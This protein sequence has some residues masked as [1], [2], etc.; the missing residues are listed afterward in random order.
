[1]PDMIHLSDGAR[2]AV[3][4]SPARLMAGGKVPPLRQRI[5]GSV[6]LGCLL[7]GAAFSLDLRAAVITPSLSQFM[8]TNT[9]ADGSVAIGSDGL[10]FVLT[11]GNTGSGAPGST[12]FFT[13]APA[14]GI[15]E[16]QYF[17]A[18]FDTP[19]FDF[20]GYLL[21]GTRI[22]L[23]DTD[24]ESGTGTF[25][26]AA[27]QKYGWY[28]STLDNTGEPGILTVTFT[29]SDSAVPEPSGLA[30]GF[31]GVAALT[32]GLRRHLHIKIKGEQFCESPPICGSS[33]HCGREYRSL[34]PNA[35]LHPK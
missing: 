19:G 26:V 31:I 33:D 13:S 5:K 32:I 23:A 4:L 3:T 35:E 14:A 11:G 28:V 2:P 34:L 24:G 1:M 29:P 10:S 30:F 8:L 17:Y 6:L 18:A 12:D 9:T 21:G 15:V 25:S 16:F 27:G 22:S 7:L 20:A